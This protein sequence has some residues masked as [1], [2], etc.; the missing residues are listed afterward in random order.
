MEKSVEVVS[1]H[2]S[3]WLDPQRA[4]TKSGKRAELHEVIWSAGF[5]EDIPSVLPYSEQASGLAV[6][7]AT[8]EYD[9]LPAKTAT[10]ARAIVDMGL[11]A[12]KSLP[13]TSLGVPPQS[14]TT[15]EAQSGYTDRFGNSQWRELAKMVLRFGGEFAPSWADTISSPDDFDRFENPS[16]VA[17]LSVGF[18]DWFKSTEFYSSEPAINPDNLHHLSSE[19]E[20]CIA[21]YRVQC[22]NA[23]LAQPPSLKSGSRLRSVAEAVTYYSAITANSGSYPRSQISLLLLTRLVRRRT[24]RDKRLS[25]SEPFRPQHP[26]ARQSGYSGHEKSFH[27]CAISR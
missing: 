21:K 24:T 3:Y 16:N 10:V 6:D 20:R 14:S 8:A 19:F 15:L 26:D 17:S 18:L 23:F 9:W 2:V 1:H 7:I 12:S 4:K 22:G 13:R 5:D 27:S 25:E 11:N